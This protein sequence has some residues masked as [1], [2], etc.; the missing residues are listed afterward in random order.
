MRSAI[1][2]FAP[3]KLPALPVYDYLD[4]F[5]NML[6]F[7]ESTYASDLRSADQ[8]SRMSRHGAERTLTFNCEADRALV[9]PASRKK[10]RCADRF[11]ARAAGRRNSCVQAG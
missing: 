4:Q 8:H 10:Q 6:S 1:D 2:V 3:V 7:V 9:A 5:T 11:C